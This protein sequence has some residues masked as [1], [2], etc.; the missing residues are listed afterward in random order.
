MAHWLSETVLVTQLEIKKGRW[1]I[2]NIGFTHHGQEYLTKVARDI[3]TDD[4][5]SY[6]LQQSDPDP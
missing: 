5:R 4:E 1:V 3:I 2:E 6:A